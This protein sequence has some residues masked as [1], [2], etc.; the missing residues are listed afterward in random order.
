MEF[1]LSETAVC[2]NCRYM[3][4]GLES[5]VCPECGR[6]FDPS[7]PITYTHR[8]HR[9]ICYR[10]IHPP[11]N[12]LRYILIGWA[13]VVLLLATDPGSPIYDVPSV[14]IA[15]PNY[16]VR[17]VPTIR[18][19]LA[20]GFICLAI[21]LQHAAMRKLRKRSRKLGV[22]PPDSPLMKWWWA[23]LC[24]SLVL[25][26][27]VYSWPIWI[28]F[29]LSRSSLEAVAKRQLA[30]GTGKLGRQNCGIYSLDGVLIYPLEHDVAFLSVDGKRYSGFIYSPDPTWE[31]D[32]AHRLGKHWHYTLSWGAK[33]W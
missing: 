13:V 17:S 30:I 12:W 7:N 6:Q 16:W 23:P 24:V 18:L 26:I 33:T 5:P 9:D 19:S 29:Q 4:R 22:A 11:R 1:N 2:L 27:A 20:M 8:S 21:A 25:S 10:W 28:G 32:F 3:L 15:G 14:L 31:R